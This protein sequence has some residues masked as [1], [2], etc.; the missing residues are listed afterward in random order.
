MKYLSD[1]DV[2]GK[3]VFIRNDFNVPLN[4]KKEILDDTRIRLSLPTMD[5]LVKQ[6]ARIVCA[7]HLG[8]PKGEKKPELSLKPVAG[9]LSE[10]LGLPVQFTGETVGKNIEQAKAALKP[11]EILLLENLRF[12]KGETENDPAFAAEL[13]RGIDVYV[14][15]AFGASHRNHASVVEITRQVPVSVPGL[16]LKK[17]VDYLT[18]ALE[19]P[20]ENYVLILGGAKVSDKIPVINNLIGKATTILIGGAMAYTF[21][22]AM[23]KKV[24]H[25][26]V[27]DEFLKMCLDILRNAEAKGVRILLPVD[28]IAAVKVEPN[29][30]I[31]MVEQGRE[32][33]E[34][35]MGLDI[36]PETVE[37]YVK[38]IRQ[39][40]LVVWNGPMG[41]FEI[42]D[43]SG[44]TMAIAH[45]IADS[46]A[47]SIVG[48]GDSVA[49]VNK[50][51]VA[52]KISHLSTG[53]GAS[54]EFLS[55]KIL[56]GIAALS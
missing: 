22:K 45:A 1:V 21:L 26:K 6:G 54:L 51:G 39:A 53:G 34:E 17:E 40:T 5:Y 20:S 11:K 41:V 31:R 3:C 23:G 12:Q 35:M 27:E 7:S 10:L 4:E 13:A 46:S 24:G 52:D 42:D 18:L 36:G 33:P 14:N 48:G 55:G 15:N 32:I 44:G 37:L 38:A 16:L 49:A 50:A 28:H 8:R 56:P 19:K 30:T 43:F 9:R 25:S 47:T 29:V 2:A